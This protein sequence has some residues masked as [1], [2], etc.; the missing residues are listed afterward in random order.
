MSLE[1]S[2]ARA[3]DAAVQG[4]APGLP[5]ADL[6]YWNALIDEKAGADFLHLKPRTM[7]S[8][9]Q[10]GGGPPYIL[11]SIRCVRYTRRRLKVWADERLRTSTADD[12][13]GVPEPHSPQTKAPTV[14]AP[15]PGPDSFSRRHSGEKPKRHEYNPT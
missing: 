8:M 12:G 14:A 10:R 11:I 15:P 13:Q 2:P 3:T 9:R 1:H 5:E 4:F 7:Q 6:A